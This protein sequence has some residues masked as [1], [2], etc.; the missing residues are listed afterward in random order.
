M[1]APSSFGKSPGQRSQ[2]PTADSSRA[3]TVHMLRFL[4]PLTMLMRTTND[5]RA[6]ERPQD[7]QGD[8]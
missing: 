4:R 8:H 1:P 5:F 3:L 7:L 6:V 2:V